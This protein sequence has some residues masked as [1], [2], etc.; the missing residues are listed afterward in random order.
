MK[1]MMILSKVS[2]NN[3]ERIDDTNMTTVDI[4]KCMSGGN[5]GL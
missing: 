2:T 3:R 4:I 5:P 1:K